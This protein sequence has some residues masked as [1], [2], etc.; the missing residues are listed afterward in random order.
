MSDIARHLANCVFEIAI[1]RTVEA[2]HCCKVTRVGI[3]KEEG[4][5]KKK[6]EGITKCQKDQESRYERILSRLHS[7]G[8]F[9]ISNDKITDGK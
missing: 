6:G 2:P 4:K 1:R 9:S 8:L 5:L 7:K 3:R